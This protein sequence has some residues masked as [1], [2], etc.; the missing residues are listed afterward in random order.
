MRPWQ[1]QA[2]ALWAVVLLGCCCGDGVLEGA[3]SNSPTATEYAPLTP[4]GASSLVAAPKPNPSSGG[5][6][7]FSGPGASN[8]DQGSSASVKSE[9][10]DPDGSPAQ[11]AA[12]S[13]CSGAPRGPHMPINA[14]LE[15]ESRWLAERD[16]RAHYTTT[17]SSMPYGLRGEDVES[18][19]HRALFGAGLPGGRGGALGAPVLAGGVSAPT[20]TL[21]RTVSDEE[22]A[23]RKPM[24][25]SAGFAGLN[26][27]T[28]M[29]LC[30]R[31]IF[32]AGG[33]VGKGE[34]AGGGGGGGQEGEGVARKRA[35]RYDKAMQLWE[36]VA[37]MASARNM[38][39]A[40]IFQ[41]PPSYDF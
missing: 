9:V 33:G 29:Q 32:A 13:A 20:R 31:Y 34:R 37:D 38:C 3:V 25:G 39:S 6:N 19:D 36:R 24:P 23:A 11:N 10:L 30:A 26:A 22:H 14:P 21:Q 5:A 28:G 27:G 41:E 17:T 4:H 2:A 1:G 40:A 12:V 35:Y 8:W 15:E 18:T 16:A 7:P